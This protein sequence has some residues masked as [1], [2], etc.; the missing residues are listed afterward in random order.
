MATMNSDT[1]RNVLEREI[2]DAHSWLASG[3]RGEQQ[4]NLQYYLGLPLGNEVD[5]RSQVVSWDVFETIEGALPNFLEPFFCRAGRRMRPMPS[6]PP[7]W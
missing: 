4:R 6:R 3:I 5:G 2:E 1:F 7:S